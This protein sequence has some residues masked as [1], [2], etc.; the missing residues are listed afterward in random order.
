[1]DEEKARGGLRWLYCVHCGQTLLADDLEKCSACGKVGG[2]LD[3][4]AP[5][6]L[7]DL[8]AKKRAS[9]TMAESGPVEVAAA[10]IRGVK[11]TLAGVVLIVLGIVLMT[12]SLLPLFDNGRI[13]RFGSP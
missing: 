12:A 6:A 3:P 11:L 7:S 5:A 10:F 8:A 9:G 4:S 1:M 2:I 13:Y